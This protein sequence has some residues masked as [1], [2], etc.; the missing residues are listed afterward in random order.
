MEGK[1][2]ILLYR[3][4]LDHSLW[5]KGKLSKGEAWI[6]ILMKANWTSGKCY[7]GNEVVSCPRGSLLTSVKSLENNWKWTTK[8]VRMFINIL[9]KDKMIT[10]TTSNKQTK[11]TVCKYDDYQTLGQTEGKQKTNGGQTEGNDINKD[12]KYNKENKLFEPPKIS[13][14]ISYFKENEFSEELAIRAFKYYESSNWIDSKNN[15]IKNWKQK[16]Q[17]VWFREENKLN[18]PKR[19]YGS[20]QGDNIPPELIGMVL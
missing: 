15:K 3:S 17:G 10:I 1:T 2:W 13:E 11:I 7:V 18:T 9:V 14:V 4:F 19:N 16:M 20:L 12:I 6:W 5:N 8:Q